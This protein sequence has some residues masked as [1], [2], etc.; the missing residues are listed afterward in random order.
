M[1]A[2]LS[3]S[4]RLF[5]QCARRHSLRSLAKPKVGLRRL[6]ASLAG[7]QPTFGNP[8]P[9]SSP[10]ETASPQANQR[11]SSVSVGTPAY[12]VPERRRRRWLAPSEETPISKYEEMIENG[13]LRP[14]EHQRTIIEKLQ[15]LHDDLRDY[16]QP[17]VAEILQRMFGGSNEVLPEPPS[18]LPRGLYLYGD[19]GTGKTM[20]MDLFYIT[21]P[22]NI[23]RKERV[24]FHAFMIDVHKRLHAYK[25]AHPHDGADPVLPI[26]RDLAKEF[27]VVC[28]DEFQVTDIA[29]AMILRRLLECMLSRHPTELYKRGIQRTSFVPAIELIMKEYDVTDLDS[30]TDYRKI[31]RALSNVYFQPLTKENKQ[32]ILK[33]FDGLTANDGPRVEEKKLVIWG[34]NVKIPESSDNVAKFSFQELCGQPLSAADYLEIT[35]RFPTVFVLDVPKMNL[36]HKDMARRF[37]T[38][39][40]ACYE[41]HTK[42]F[43]S[44]EVPIYRI[45]SD[46][47]GGQQAKE[48]TDHIRSIMDD[49]GISDQQ[50]G[51]T[52]I[53][54]G[55]EE[56]FA[57]ARACSR[58]IQMG[59]QE[60]ALTA[61]QENKHAVTL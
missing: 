35:K 15:R 51:T 7:V 46:D 13:I 25:L 12:R 43:V 55:E 27:S 40:D 48:K 57:F 38:F 17:P 21:L 37:I 54:D 26:A 44:S 9:L 22:A 49:L 30:G 61:G 1:T 5:L 41:N 29:V 10:S 42:L 16:E 53:F 2:T 39:I 14:D 32:E 3:L 50:V 47:T 23:K 60:W 31:P 8:S 28:F 45:F 19:V 33:I 11:S 6:Q 24:H 59:T 52:S 18:D 34:R 4:R 20:L 56:L 36:N 58:L